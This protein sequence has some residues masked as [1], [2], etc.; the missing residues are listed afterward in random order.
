MFEL[1]AMPKDALEMKTAIIT[2]VR[3]GIGQEV[4]PDED[5]DVGLAK[6][7][8]KNKKNNK[9]G[10]SAYGMDIRRNRLRLGY[11]RRAGNSI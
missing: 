5:V 4:E 10:I 9:S 2:A 7:A 1:T 8:A 11:A 6:L 3:H